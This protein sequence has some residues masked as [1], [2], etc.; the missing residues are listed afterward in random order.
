MHLAFH[1]VSI[2]RERGGYVYIAA[3]LFIWKYPN[4]FAAV[5]RDVPHCVP[6]LRHAVLSGARSEEMALKLIGH[7]SLVRHPGAKDAP[8]TYEARH[9][10]VKWKRRKTTLLSYHICRWKKKPKSRTVCLR[11]RMGIKVPVPRC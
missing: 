10:R 8:P 6:R 5:G 1:H 7:V 4:R 9:L 11:I 3:Y 2:P